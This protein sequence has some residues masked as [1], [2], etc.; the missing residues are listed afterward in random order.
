MT[1][2]LNRQWLMEGV[3]G[4]RQVYLPFILVCLVMSSDRAVADNAVARPRAA[5]DVSVRPEHQ[6]AD[7]KT[8]NT[9]E[10]IVPD[11]PVRDQNG[12]KLQFYTD[13]VKG[14]KVIVNFIYTTCKGVCPI[15]GQ[16]FAKLQARLGDRLGRDVFMISV[17]TDPE[18]DS[19]TKLKA[20]SNKYHPAPG[21]T[22]VTGNKEDIASLLRV[23]TGDGVRSGYH[24]PAV[25][26]ID[27]VNKAQKWNY[28]F[29]PP[30]E[31]VRMIDHMAF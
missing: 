21:W 13:L 29:A 17:T 7:G 16:S 26:V 28:G 9:A 18:N 30:E 5:K 23:L 10:F 1:T 4:P 15:S 19:P 2:A 14:R 25:C 24:V 12:R 6:A 31:I 11:V 22:L 20:W 8:D 3:M 27:D